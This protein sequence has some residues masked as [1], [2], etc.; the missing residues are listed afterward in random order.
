M[1]EGIKEH[2][3]EKL[4][5]FEKYSSRLVE[6]HVILNKEKYLYEAEVTLLAKH[7]KACGKASSKENIYAAI[8]L[9][10]EKVE[11]QLKK[12]REKLKDHH[13]K[14]GEESIRKPT[15]LHNR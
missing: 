2:L 13:K 12:F 5:K 14:H 11:K 8:D 3:R 15:T 1:T 6:S 9:A 7:L 4:S 10:C